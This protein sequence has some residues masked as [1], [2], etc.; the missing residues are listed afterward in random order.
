MRGTLK[1]EGGFTL[2]EA[3]VVLCVAGML[4]LVTV[5]GMARAFEQASTRSLTTEIKSLIVE[6]QIRA[7]SRRTYVALVFEDTPRGATARLYADEDWDGVTRED[8]RRGADRPLGSAVLLKEE[9]AFLGIPPEVTRDPVGQPLRSSDP[10]RFGRGAI[11]S[12][13]PTFT[14]TPGSI[15]LRDFPG[16]EAWAFR[17]AG[18]DGRLRVYRWWRGRWTEAK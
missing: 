16:R 5:G 6:A 14:A 9:R 1:S 10:V 13:S 17:V 15:Y 7:V 2:P 11:L 8:I 3:L 4:V 18:V 12:F